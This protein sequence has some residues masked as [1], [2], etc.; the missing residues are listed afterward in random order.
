MCSHGRI[1]GRNGVMGRRGMQTNGKKSGVRKEASGQQ[2]GPELLVHHLL[3]S[4]GKQML[5][6]RL[7]YCV[8]GDSPVKTCCFQRRSCELTAATDLWWGNSLP[9]HT[10]SLVIAHINDALK[11]V[12]I[13]DHGRSL[14][15]S[16]NTAV[17]FMQRHTGNRVPDEQRA[18]C[19]QRSRC[20]SCPNH[21]SSWAGDETQW[22]SACPASA[23]PWVYL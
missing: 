19:K 2:Q 20:E 14:C 8:F 21:L 16:S 5:K 9:S 23:K 3:P 7:Q 12:I 13:L 22:Q 1:V 11:S 6:R 4:G 18:V 10:C 15:P 17:V